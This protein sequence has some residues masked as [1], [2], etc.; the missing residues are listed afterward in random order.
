MKTNEQKLDHLIE[1]V[2][3]ISKQPGNEWMASKLTESFVSSPRNKY[4]EEIGVIKQYLSNITQYL[5]L[6]PQKIIDYSGFPEDIKQSLMRDNI[7]MNRYETGTSNH[8]I[9]FPE[10]CRYALKQIEGMLNYFLLKNANDNFHELSK[11]IFKYLTKKEKYKGPLPKQ[12]SHITC[13]QKIYF[14][15]KLIQIPPETLE[16][17]YF[18]NY[19]RNEQSHTKIK[20]SQ[21]NNP[22][23]NDDKT[24]KIKLS[25]ENFSKINELLEEIKKI[26]VN[27]DNTLISKYISKNESNT[28]GEVFPEL[29]D[30]LTD[31]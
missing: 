1:F 30:I 31:K 27:S 11:F 10:F 9:D 15:S 19:V 7:E 23:S 20:E 17:L 14:F 25:E 8:K 13:K 21:V 28:L 18:L 3:E 26:I 2:K 4:E 22:I 16:N 6:Q 29:K 5:S 12:I 24:F